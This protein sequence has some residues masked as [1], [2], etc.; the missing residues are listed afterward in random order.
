M[1]EQTKVLESVLANGQS[2]LS[3]IAPNLW[4][5]EQFQSRDQG[6]QTS[7]AFSRKWDELEHGGSD[8]QKMVDDQ[9]A[10]YLELY[11]FDSE[12]DL[13]A[14][15]KNCKAIIDC[16][17]GKGNKAAWFAEL[18]PS[19][20]VIGADV[21]ES[22]YA[23]AA[24]YRET[25]KNLIFVRCD[26]A[27]MDFLA[28]GAFDYVNCDQVIHHTEDPPATFKQ[29]VRLTRP[30]RDLTCYVYRKKAL[31][32]ELLDDFF[33]E[34]CKS[35]SHDEL[36]DLSRQLTDLGRMLDTVEGE[37]DFPAIPALSINGGRMSVQRFVYWNFIKCYWNEKLGYDVSVLTNYDW[38]APSQAFR[39][40]REEFQAWIDAAGLATTYFHEE[41]ACYSGRFQRP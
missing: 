13:A 23:S 29:L 14:H 40:S 38:Y 34:H 16:G 18:N 24:F 7:E 31:P 28:K 20:L 8:F 9:K 10:W 19:A 1:T 15:L 37:M 26:I 21:S 6:S 3:A 27:H 30:G 12:D 41:P 11:G 17:T 2:T 32:R 4:V 33:R 22:V 35:L 25:H 5:A 36:M 39:Y